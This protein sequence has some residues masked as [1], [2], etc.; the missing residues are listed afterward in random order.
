MASGDGKSAHMTW[1]EVGDLAFQAGADLKENGPA[2]AGPFL[3]LC[4]L[5]Q[6]NFQLKLN[7]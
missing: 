5:R 7:M 3:S 1:I 4:G 2:C 6:L